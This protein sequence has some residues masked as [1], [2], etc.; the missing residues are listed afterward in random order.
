MAGGVWARSSLPDAP[1]FRQRQT[2]QPTFAFA[3]DYAPKL[4]LD[5]IRA[6]GAQKILACQACLSHHAFEYSGGCIPPCMKAKIIVTPKKAVVDPQGKTVQSALAH[7]G[8][9]SITSVHVGKYI[10]IDLAPDTVLVLAPQRETQVVSHEP[11][12]SIGIN[13]RRETL[14]EWQ[15]PLAALAEWEPTP[16][17]SIL[18]A[19]RK[20]VTR[21][22]KW[23]EVLFGL[24]APACKTEDEAA[25]WVAAIRDRVQ[26]HLLQ[27]LGHHVHATP[28]S[29]AHRVA[30]YDLA[31][32]ALR[33]IPP[34]G[35]PCLSVTDLAQGLGV[36]RRAVEYAFRSL[37][38]ISPAQYILAERLN[39]VRY[40]LVTY[41]V[42]VTKVAFDHEFNNLGRFAYQYARLFGE[43]PSDT[44]RTAIAAFTRG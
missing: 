12:M 19:D 39:K 28:L 27:M 4:A 44:L 8:Y 10:E 16:E 9:N 23:V 17:G 32:A 30:R 37:I 42:P 14:A 22:R 38:G 20:A 33:M 34:E 18:E 29:T 43:R 7:M 5:A 35:E 36:S 41:G 3:C 15:A 6:G 2:A 11:W 40:H 26:W 24:R 25:M 21:F 31:L 1:N 13:V